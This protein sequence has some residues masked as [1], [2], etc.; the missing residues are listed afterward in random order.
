MRVLD[1]LELLGAGAGFDEI[2]T[3]YPALERDHLLAALTYAP[4]A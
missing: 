3:D 4:T 2:L 1:V